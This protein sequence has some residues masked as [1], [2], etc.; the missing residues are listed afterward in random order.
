MVII[1]RIQMED[2]NI[3]LIGIQRMDHIILQHR[4]GMVNYVKC[5]LVVIK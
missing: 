1:V 5:M 2:L 4:L 3:H